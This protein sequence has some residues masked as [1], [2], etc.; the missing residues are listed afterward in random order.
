MTTTI[1]AT[2]AGTE[3]TG[4][5]DDVGAGE[6]DLGGSLGDLKSA[7]RPRDLFLGLRGSIG[8][9]SKFFDNDNFSIIFL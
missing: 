5:G 6:C 3:E 8:G 9:F 1:T 7:M 4:D 2:G